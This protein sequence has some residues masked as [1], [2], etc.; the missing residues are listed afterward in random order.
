MN[1]LVT[2][3]GVI[4]WQ[5][6]RYRCA[7]GTNKINQ[8]IS[9]GDGVTPIGCF[10]MR[11]VYY[12]AD[13]VGKPT[14]ALPVLNIEPHAGWCDEPGHPE[15]NKLVYQ[16]FAASHEKLWRDD[17]IYDVIVELGFNDAPVIPG[18]GSAIFIHISRPDYAPTQ[19]CVAM[20][21]PLLLQILAD[22][23]P[24]TRVTIRS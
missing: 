19:G 13:R 17:H 24:T 2:P 18:I 11:A 12:R 23:N 6:Q 8:K 21:E 5:D 9:E 22:C 3:P 20:P 10:P 4:T 1:L 16:P 14:T 15:Y 7:V